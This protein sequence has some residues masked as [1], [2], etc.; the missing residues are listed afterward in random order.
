MD[1]FN[2]LTY[3]ELLIALAAVILSFL[4][5]IRAIKVF[6]LLTSFYIFQWLLKY[7]FFGMT[8][9]GV[10]ALVYAII[11]CPV[12]CYFKIKQLRRRNSV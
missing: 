5:P 12:I 3:L 2:T 1:A 9:F 7:Y 11:S 6:L 4:K 10:S 8:H